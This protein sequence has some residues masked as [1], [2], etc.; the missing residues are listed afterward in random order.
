VDLPSSFT[1]LPTLAA[2]LLPDIALIFHVNTA[3]VTLWSDVMGGHSQN[4]WQAPA[5]I[6]SAHIHRDYAVLSTKGGKVHLIRGSQDE[7]PMEPI[8]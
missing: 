2:A 6:T 1:S 8:A 5:E 3:G 7:E 4:S